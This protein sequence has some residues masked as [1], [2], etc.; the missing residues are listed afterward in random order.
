MSIKEFLPIQ[1]VSEHGEYAPVISDSLHGLDKEEKAERSPLS[2]PN[3]TPV[4]D[5]D[6]GFSL[7]D[8]DHGPS[9]P[10]GGQGA[11]EIQSMPRLESPQDQAMQRRGSLKSV[12]SNDD[13]S[14]FFLRSISSHDNITHASD[15][16][17]TDSGHSLRESPHTEA[18]PSPPLRLN[19]SPRLSAPASA[20]PRERPMPPKAEPFIPQIVGST[21]KEV[22]FARAQGKKLMEQ[23]PVNAPPERPK[24]DRE[25]NN[26]LGGSGR[27]MMSRNTA[28]NLRQLAMKASQEEEK[29]GSARRRD[30][31]NPARKKDA[32]PEK[33]AAKTT[34]AV[35]KDEVA[36]AKIVESSGDFSDSD[37]SEKEKALE[38]RVLDRRESRRLIKAEQRRSSS[39]NSEDG[40]KFEGSK[41]PGA[42]SAGSRH[43][44]H[45]VDFN[46]DD[47][48][49]SPRKQTRPVL[50]GRM[51]S[52]PLSSSTSSRRH[53]HKR[54]NSM[55]SSTH[56]F[57]SHSHRILRGSTSSDSDE[58]G[59]SR[60]HR[61]RKS[62]TKLRRSH[63]SDDSDNASVSSDASSRSTVA[64]MASKVT[65]IGSGIRSGLTCLSRGLSLSALPTPAEGR[66]SGRGDLFDS[67]EEESYYSSD[68]SSEDDESE[69]ECQPWDVNIWTEG[70]YYV[71][72]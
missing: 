65:S 53:R 14:G 56:A 35:G 19:T 25:M 41:L 49:N 71:A 29:Q 6:V 44:A 55:P 24:L 23:E 43:S 10:F 36:P 57:R 8:S 3:V 68:Y 12:Q 27:G 26:I 17:M 16:E 70:E 63:T 15:A 11:V 5:D 47:V 13:N 64:S 54:M 34:R 60:R 40:T 58:S 48:E 9:P 18:T 20:V 46:L 50:G 51:N 2:T 1:P 7:D 61:R 33:R 30:R 42:K 66:G 52:Q 45:N 62:K 67:E 37:K 59:R 4:D 69:I 31:E 38:R 39:S 28:L 21:A 32:S 72:M 22:P